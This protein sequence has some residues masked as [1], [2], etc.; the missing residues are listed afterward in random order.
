MEKRRI[1]LPRS[2]RPHCP[3]GMIFYKTTGVWMDKDV[4]T[5]SVFKSPFHSL[6]VVFLWNKEGELGVVEW[7]SWNPIDIPDAHF[8]LLWCWISRSKSAIWFANHVK[9]FHE[10]KLKIHDLF[11]LLWYLLPN[12]SVNVIRNEWCIFAYF[13]NIIKV[14]WFPIQIDQL[15]TAMAVYD[16]QE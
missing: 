11:N 8:L 2:S 16:C 1:N 4:K 6:L 15:N 5:V 12:H 10:L 9:L 7:P 14:L 3:N 13:R